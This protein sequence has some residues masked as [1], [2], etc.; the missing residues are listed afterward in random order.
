MISTCPSCKNQI[1]VP[2]TALG[3]K[4]R[5][6][7]C[8]AVFVVE[9]GAAVAP[10]PPPPPPAPPPVSAPARAPDPPPARKKSTDAPANKSKK[11]K[12]EPEPFDEIEFLPDEPVKAPKKKV[13]PVKKKAAPK[14][15]AADDPFNFAA[16][17][18]AKKKAPDKKKPPEKPKLGKPE[19]AFDFINSASQAGPAADFGFAEAKK[20]TNVGI[21]LRASSAAS[22]MRFGVIFS[23]VPTMAQVGLPIAFGMN[24]EEYAIFSVGCC[25]LLMF[26]FAA[27]FVMLGAR[28]LDR[29]SSFGMAIFGANVSLLIGLANL[30]LAVAMVVVVVIIATQGWSNIASFAVVA[31]FLSFIQGFL[32]LWGGIR[33][34]LVSM[35]GEVRAIMASKK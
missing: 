3:K 11:P 27:V 35:N 5:C 7:G 21:Q 4:V 33:G 9:A 22:F 1:E 10:A 18:A 19:N 15:A 17:N 29:L 30:A 25:P 16:G 34:A 20:K 2:A 6:S 12:P 14:P 23:V 26:L 32:S 8:Q 28:A 24:R 31:A 13:E